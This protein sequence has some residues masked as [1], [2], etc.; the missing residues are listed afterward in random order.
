[1]DLAALKDL[2]NRVALLK[3]NHPEVAILKISPVTV[4]EHG[5][6]VL[7]AEVQVGNPEQRTDTVRRA[8][9]G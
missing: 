2:L 3:D 4:S 6:S 1:M 9:R 7:A 5:L 8:L